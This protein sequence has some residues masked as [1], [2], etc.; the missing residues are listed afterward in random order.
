MKNMAISV[1]DSRISQNNIRTDPK[2]RRVCTQ[3]ESKVYTRTFDKRIRK[4][5]HICCVPYGYREN[6][7][8]ANK[9]V[10]HVDICF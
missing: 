10:G 7:I 2:R 1:D 3:V 8:D 4:P 6:L 5:D 9:V